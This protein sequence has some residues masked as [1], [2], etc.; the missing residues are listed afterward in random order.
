MIDRNCPDID[1]L[2]RWLAARAEAREPLIGEHIRR[3]ADCTAVVAAGALELGTPAEVHGPRPESIAPRRPERWAFV[4]ALAV[5]VIVA[6]EVAGHGG[7]ALRFGGSGA[8]SAEGAPESRPKS[9]KP[10]ANWSRDEIA[11]WMLAGRSAEGNRFAELFAR[12]GK[13]RIRE[14][15][16]MAIKAATEESVRTTDGVPKLYVVEAR[17]FLRLWTLKEIEE[18]CREFGNEWHPYEDAVRRILERGQ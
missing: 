14:A 18:A 10:I 6:F 15:I 16:P 5:V 11:E 2:Y 4:A 1:S 9:K 12:S 8:S 7:R 13:E 17:K 3:C